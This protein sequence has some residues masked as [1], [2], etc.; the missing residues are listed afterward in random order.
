MFQSQPNTI[1]KQS[2]KTNR[3]LPI[4]V[5]LSFLLLSLTSRAQNLINATNS[6]NWEDPTIWDSGTVPGTN[7]YVDIP[8]G[9]DVT[10]ASNAIVQYIQD[11]G[12][13]TMAPYAT[14]NIIGDTNGAY[15]AQNLGVL[16]ATATGNTVIYSGNAYWAQNVSYYNLV[17]SGY[18]TFWNG[19]VSPYDPEG[20]TTIAGNLTVSGTAG[21]QDDSLITVDGN[22]TLGGIGSSNIVWDSSQGGLTILGTTVVGSGAVVKTLDANGA[23]KLNNL[24][25]AGGIVNLGDSTN[26]FL[27][28]NFTNNSGTLKGIAYSAINF[29]G[30]TGTITGTPFT[31]KTFNVTGTYA[32]STTIN[33]ATNTPGLDGSTLVFDL[34]NPGQIVLSPNA[35]QGTNL[36]AI[37]T[38]YYPTNGNLDVINSGP[39]PA[40]GANYQFFSAKSYSGTFASI[41]LPSLPNGL[42]W[43]NNLAT[44]GSITVIGSLLTPPVLT[45]SRNGGQLTLSWNSTTYP[46]Y[47]VQAQTNK[48]GL[49]GTWTDVGSGTN[50]PYMVTINP[51]N[52]PVYYRLSNP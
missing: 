18:G 39:T 32:I 15:G 42:S 11:L 20:P 31:I 49:G 37:G 25:I 4:L 22:A 3:I 1:H 46:G 6:G 9:I 33:V 43:V 29:F 36:A 21:L 13:V 16:D 14:L 27:T 24:T 28:G 23:D 45:L 7:D 35:N 26:W 2:M 50:S 17:F 41:S 12:T 44:G 48:T 30:T 40:P 10:V 8:L 34:A 38:L 5:T 19:G 52:P 47:E 51:T